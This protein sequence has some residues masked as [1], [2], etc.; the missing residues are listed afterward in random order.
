MSNTLRFDRPIS[1]GACGAGPTLQLPMRRTLVIALLA[2]PA[3]AAAQAPTL[4][5]ARQLIDKYIVAIGGKDAILGRKSQ[6][7]IGTMEVPS[8]NLRGDMDVRT[9]RPNLILTKILIPGIGEIS[10]GF[11][12]TV[13][14]SITPMTGPR[15]VAG[16]ELETLREDSDPSNV[17]RPAE[18]L[19]SAE[20]VEQT[21]FGGQACYKVKLVWKSGR[22]SYDCYSVESGL[23][24]ATIARQDTPMGN[25]E[26]TTILSDYRDFGGQKRPAK[27]TQ[28][29]MGQ[30]TVIM[31]LSV[32]YDNV[33]PSVFELPREIKALAEKTAKPN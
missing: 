6:H 16:K 19:A 28:D 14:W 2:M 21:Q 8:Q 18:K 30:Q 22:E 3:V 12:G 31:V 20:T 26:A 10:S 29:T 9:A 27:M 1:H 33:D 5:P 13:G 32:E 17:L 15:L 25:V 23:L 7:L 11:N 24:V 4:P